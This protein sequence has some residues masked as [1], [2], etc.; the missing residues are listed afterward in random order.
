M[1]N[2]L[3]RIAVFSALT[4]SGQVYATESKL[5]INGA[6]EVEMSGDQISAPKV[7][8]EFNQLLNQQVNADMVLL[9]EQGETILDTA[10]INF[11]PRGAHWSMSLGYLFVPFGHF[12]TAMAFDPINKTL[13]ESKEQALLYDFQL[14]NLTTSL[15][16][17]N[18]TNNVAGKSAI[19]NY[20]IQF[21]H[22]SEFMRTSF[23]Y[24]NDIGDSNVLQQ[25]INTQ[26]GNNN[27]NT[28]VAGQS[29]AWSLHNGDFALNTELVTTQ[30]AFQAGQLAATAVQPST[31]NIE[32]NY[33]FHLAGS[34]SILA[35]GSQ[36]S[37]DAAALAIPKAR[38]M[39][40]VNT[41]IQKDASLILQLAQDT[42]YSDV[43]TSVYAVKLSVEF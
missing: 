28:M 23:G 43:V 30:T 8:L 4:L 21:T 31:T 9:Y 33:R 25:L 2:I 24:I 7:E 34:E 40:A 32:V 10:A 11:A 39:L 42:D 22:A 5:S 27:T 36:S 12:D 29:I 20:G 35:V 37:V 13:A 41:T 3:I 16:W 38:T 14:S 17:F 18:G 1:N 15:Y 26:L 6:L 19:D